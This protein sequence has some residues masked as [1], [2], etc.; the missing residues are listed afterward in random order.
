ME[1]EDGMYEAVF[2]PDAYCKNAKIIAASPF[3]IIRGRLHF[4][5]NNVSIIAKDAISVAAVKKIKRMRNEENIKAEFLS[6]T[7]NLWG[8]VN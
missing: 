8:T 5:D 7:K 4:K 2:F 3:L 6:K 1:D